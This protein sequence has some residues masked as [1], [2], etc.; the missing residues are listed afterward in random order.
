MTA[1][2][3][4]AK[5]A[6]P[7]TNQAALVDVWDLPLRLF[8]WLLVLAVAVAFLS[9]EGDSPLNQWHVLAGWVAGILIVFR[10]VWGF[11]GGEHARFANF[12][13]PGRI[14]EHVTGLFRRRGNPTLGHNPLGGI[15]VVILLALTAVTVV[16]GAFG[17]EAVED[18]H[19]LV[20]WTLL[21]F[22]GLHIAAV[23]IMSFAERENLIRAMITGKK[24][25]ARHSGEADAKRPGVLSG[26]VAIVV[27][28]ATIYGILQYDP[29][30]FTLRRAEAFEQ[31]AGAADA[32]SQPKPHD[33]ED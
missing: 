21:A 13:R 17:G 22:I 20:A 2:A 28:A 24:A 1:T 9:S 16:S 19:E 18:F 5:A 29:Q 11:I 10:V 25:A 7:A 8:H 26:L 6:P 23:V 33:D 27:L 4:P 12:L 15:S 31:R 3:S 14:G 30:A 32:S